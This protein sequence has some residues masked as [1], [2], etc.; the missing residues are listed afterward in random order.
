MKKAFLSALVLSAAVALCSCRATNGNNSL[1]RNNGSDGSD[2]MFGT[3]QTNGYAY[4]G[5]GEAGSYN[6][7]MANGAVN[8][9]DTVGN[10]VNGANGRSYAVGEPGGMTGTST[11]GTS[12]Y[13]NGANNGQI[14]T[15]NGS[16]DG[17]TG[18]SSYGSTST[19]GVNSRT[20]GGSSVSAY[21]K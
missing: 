14:N 18:T 21:T 2:G 1:T 12:N 5:T 8:G 10:S 19:N 15:N 9:G 6:Y 17:G 11:A 13:T 4:S 7:G 3:N 20:A 16:A